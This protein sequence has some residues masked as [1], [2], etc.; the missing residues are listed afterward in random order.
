MTSCLCPL[1]RT[2]IEN[3]SEQY[4]ILGCLQSRKN[5][6]ISKP[7]IIYRI[8]KQQGPTIE[9]KE[10]YSIPVINDNGNNMKKEYIS[11]TESLCYIAEI[12]KTL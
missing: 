3:N 11:V 8:N 12:N 6:K 5:R 1:L 2:Q 4:S 9:Y 7:N 10:L